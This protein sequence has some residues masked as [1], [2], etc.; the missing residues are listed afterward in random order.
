MKQVHREKSNEPNYE[1]MN[2]NL[3]SKQ[4]KISINATFSFVYTLSLVLSKYLDL[5]RHRRQF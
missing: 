3:N 5:A 1:I 2:V 4:N